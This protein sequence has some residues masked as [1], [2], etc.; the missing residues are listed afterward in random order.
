MPSIPLYPPSPS[1]G[2]SATTNPLPSVLQT[3]LG[4]ALLEIQGTIHSSGSISLSS[5]TDPDPSSNHSNSPNSNPNANSNSN[6]YDESKGSQPTNDTANQS[7]ADT[8]KSTQIG[9]LVFPEYTPSTTADD[10]KWMKKVYLYVGKHQ[11]MSGEVRELGRAV[12]VLRRKSPSSSNLGP[13][14][15]EGDGAR[16]R[17][18]ERHGDE[19]GEDRDELEI[20]E[21][22]RY[23]LVFASRP[24]PVGTEEVIART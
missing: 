20:A 5:D 2:S 4:L 19:D 9:R 12:A 14:I 13:G 3:P 8:S 17:A 11:R 16:A 18:R 24:E 10:K 23:K 15:G 22:I 21:I 1:S 6:D 7:L